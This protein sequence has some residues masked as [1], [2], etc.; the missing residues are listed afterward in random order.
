VP[1]FSSPCSL[2]DPL[3]DVL[4]VL[5]PS[6]YM[7]RAIDARG[8][9]S[10][11]FSGLDGI[12]CYAVQA[13]AVWIQIEGE[14]SPRELRAG[15]CMVLTGRQSLKMGS[16]LD[17]AAEDAVAVMTSAPWGGA[18]TL[19]GGGEIYGLGGFFLFE[20]RHT[21]QLL[22]ALPD[23]MHLDEQTESATLRTAMDVVMSELREPRPGGRLVAQQTAL[24][25]LVLLL[26]QQLSCGGQARPGWLQ[27]L[28]APKISRA[29]Q[30]IHANP[31]HGWDLVSLA[32][33]AGMSRSALALHFRDKV[34][35]PPMAYL[36]RWRMTLASDRLLHGR[37]RIG[38]IAADVGYISDS[39]FCSVFKKAMG[40]SPRAYR[41]QGAM[42]VAH[43]R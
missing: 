30:A 37:D 10:L 26:R 34:G 32:R 12:R 36:Q 20:D 2:S 28:S 21:I 4:G 40:C 22:E 3:S 41:R 17:L 14:S 6:N 1:P 13:G 9:W 38:D 42:A 33:Q 5:R 27:G 43:D 11:A 19:N 24:S 31:A 18:V 15:N 35:E 16:R 7:F 8:D 29:L 23:V 39:A 25:I